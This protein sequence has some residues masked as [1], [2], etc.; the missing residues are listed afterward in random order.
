MCGRYALA[1]WPSQI[2]QL[3]RDDNMPVHEALDD[4]DEGSNESSG[5]GGGAG[6]DGPIQTYNFAPSYRGIVYR[7]ARPDQPRRPQESPEDKYELQTMKWG[8]NP[9][10]APSIK[11]IINCRDD[12]LGQSDRVWS[13]VKAHNRCVVVAQGYYEWLKRDGGRE[14]LPYYVRRKDGKLMCFAGL[15][16]D[17][18]NQFTYAIITTHPT[19]A[20]AFLHDRMPVI[21]ENGSENMRKWL[22]CGGNWSKELQSLLGPYEGELEAY[23]VSKEVGRV[24]NNSPKFVIP[25]DSGDNKDNIANYFAKGAGRNRGKEAAK[26]EDNGPDVKTE[27]DQARAGGREKDKPAVGSR[28]EEG[29]HRIKREDEEDREGTFSAGVKRKADGKSAA[30]QEP[31]PAKV[32]SKARDKEQ[33][34]GRG[35]KVSPQKG[36]RPKI[37]ATKNNNNAQSPTKTKSKS[38]GTQKITKFFQSSN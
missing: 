22:D 19:R 10:N 17:H 23:Q 35:K 25:V 34:A 16:S 29:G 7:T 38:A 14:A 3:L 13:P 2:R 12:S 27:A 5:S 36:G 33:D 28:K 15:W 11:G 9:P 8:L 18:D 20:L 32:R 21:L 31:P 37:S 26:G 6:H 1:L 24:G 4:P 30:A